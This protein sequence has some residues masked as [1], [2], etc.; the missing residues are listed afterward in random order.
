MQQ[1]LG[2]TADGKW[3]PQSQAAAKEQWGLSD[4]GS[5]WAK[6]ENNGVTPEP[7]PVSDPDY[8]SW[9]QG[10]WEGYFASIRQSEGQ[11]AAEEELRYFTKKGLIP[12]KMVNYAAIGA[13]GGQ[14]G[15]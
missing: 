7:E 10:D 5:A 1:A 13:R 4:A 9:D 15:H 12:Q 8:S 2:V 3:G 14:K 6:Y 11:A